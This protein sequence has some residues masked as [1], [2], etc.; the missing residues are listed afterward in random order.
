VVKYKCNIIYERRIDMNK[1]IFIFLAIFMALGVFAADSD[2]ETS[3]V[4][5]IF[6]GF[7]DGNL[8]DGFKPNTS[9]KMMDG[10]TSLVNG[11]ILRSSVTTDPYAS[12]STNI[13]FSDYSEIKIRMRH[14]TPGHSD[15]FTQVFFSGMLADGSAFSYNQTDSVK[16][17][18]GESTS[19][20]VTHVL[21]LD[22][23]KQLE[24]AV[25]TGMRFDLVSHAGD[26]YVDYIQLVPESENSDIVYTFD[27][28]LSPWTSANAEDVSVQNGVL[29]GVTTGHNGLIANGTLKFLGA[30]YPK[31]Y[32]RMMLGEE[33]TGNNGLTSDRDSLFYTNLADESGTVIKPLYTQYGNYNYTSNKMLQAD[34]GKYKT[35]TYDFS[36]Y[37]E[38]LNN[39]V[40]QMA[41]NM[42]NTKGVKFNID[43][44]LFKNPDSLEWNFECEGLTEGWTVSD[45]DFVVEDGKL[46]YTHNSE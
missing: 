12:Y 14:N 6:L 13:F 25:I 35:Y 8:P 17:I 26:I 24:G 9:M 38:Y 5:T 39:T 20:Y 10:D 29:T 7:D 27:G 30:I 4:P 40:T 45:S 19:D 16:Q 44:I 32:I 31:V 33:G 34:N 41:F 42:V 2:D 1:L 22:T 18:I 43:T 15:C 36:G 3:Y 11:G 21:K 28:S 46:K 23:L 37:S